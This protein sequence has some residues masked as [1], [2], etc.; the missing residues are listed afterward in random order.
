MAYP[1]KDPF[2]WPNPPWND[3][4][5]NPTVH[6]MAP[7]PQGK[8]VDRH[9]PP[10]WAKTLGEADVSASQY[11]FFICPCVGTGQL[12]VTTPDGKTRSSF[13]IRRRVLLNK[14]GTT[15]RYVI[16]KS[17]GQAQIDPIKP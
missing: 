6:T 4:W 9:I 15:Y 13:V 7:G 11:Y 14:D 3:S 2:V 10:R 8:F 5:V 17:G 1:G 16:N 12:T